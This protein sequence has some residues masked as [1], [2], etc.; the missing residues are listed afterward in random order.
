MAAEPFPGSE[1]VADVLRFL[2]GL[3]AFLAT[4]SVRKIRPAFPRVGREHWLKDKLE[5]L[6]EALPLLGI[7]D[8]ERPETATP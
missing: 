7:Q 5:P 1:R 4:A 2:S 6:N 8:R 3:G